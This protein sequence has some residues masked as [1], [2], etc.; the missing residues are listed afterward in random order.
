MKKVLLVSF[1]WRERTGELAPA[2]IVSSGASTG[3]PGRSQSRTSSGAAVVKAHKVRRTVEKSVQV[4][5]ADNDTVVV[6]VQGSLRLEYHLSVDVDRPSI[7]SARTMSAASAASAASLCRFLARLCSAAAV[8]PCSTA[9]H[10]DT[11]SSASTHPS[12]ETRTQSS[13]LE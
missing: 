3:I 12:A 10:R 4:V 7:H 1:A 11:A 5:V 13:V 6:A 9:T 8:L 2:M